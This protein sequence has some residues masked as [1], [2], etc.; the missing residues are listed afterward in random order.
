MFIYGVAVTGAKG[1]GGGGLTNESILLLCS[2]IAAIEDICF[3]LLTYLIKLNETLHFK[4]SLP[5]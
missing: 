1:F 2:F 3:I 5:S 4:T